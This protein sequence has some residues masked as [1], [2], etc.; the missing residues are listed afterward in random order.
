MNSVPVLQLGVQPSGRAHQVHDWHRAGQHHDLQQEGQE[1]S[2]Q[3][4]SFLSRSVSESA[5]AFNISMIWAL[6][7]AL[8]SSISLGNVPEIHSIKGFWFMCMSEPVIVSVAVSLSMSE[9]VCV[10]ASESVIV[11]LSISEPV[12]VAMSDS[13]TVSM[14]EPTG[15]VCV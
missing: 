2:R 12:F 15:C 9:P 1:P 5:A 6:Y 10:A 8:Q 7:H 11:S 3:S 14:S 4:G 13:V